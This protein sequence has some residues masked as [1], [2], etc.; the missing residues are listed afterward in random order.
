MRPAVRLSPLLLA[1]LLAGCTLGPDFQRPDS[2][3]PGNGLR[4]KVKPLTASHKPSRWNCA[5]GTPSMT[6][7]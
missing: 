7:A 5:G 6:H 2:E 1:V 4:C 3:A